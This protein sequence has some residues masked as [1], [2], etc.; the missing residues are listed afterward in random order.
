MK[1]TVEDALS[2]SQGS[3]ADGGL[4][5]EYHFDFLIIIVVVVDQP[6]SDDTR[7]S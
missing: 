1:Y 7:A 5:F 6:E 3:N 4:K 2:S